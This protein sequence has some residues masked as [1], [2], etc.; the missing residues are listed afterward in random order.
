M[1]NIIEVTTEN[2]DEVLNQHKLLLLDFWAQWCVPCKA[3]TKVVEQIAPEF[4]EFTFGSIDIDKEKTLAEEFEIRSVPSI[5]ILRDEVVVYA[6]S[7]AL[8]ATALKDLLNQAKA[9]NADE[10]D[11]A[12]E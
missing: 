6:N 3:F 4:P 9:L 12:K 10:L 7:G 5:M 11:A 8:T 1:M 2:F